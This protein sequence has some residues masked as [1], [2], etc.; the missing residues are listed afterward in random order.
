V[1][2]N[3][4]NSV[5]FTAVSTRF[6]VFYLIFCYRTK[7]RCKEAFGGKI[8]IRLLLCSSDFLWEP[9]GVGEVCLKI[10]LRLFIVIVSEF[11]L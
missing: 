4:W 6:N 5:C 11:L 7:F 8:Q 3:F 9:F 1:Q 2:S 10:F